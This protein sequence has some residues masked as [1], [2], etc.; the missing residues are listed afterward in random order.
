MSHEPTRPDPLQPL[1]RRYLLSGDEEAMDRLVDRT[2]P[3]L[4]AVARRIGAPQDAEDAV[5]GAYMALVRKRG[6]D[7]EAPVMP[8]L[9][10]T[11]IRLAYRRKAKH[12][13][14]RELASRLSR[15][16]DGEGPD[17]RA[18]DTERELLVRTAVAKLPATYRDAV[19]LRHLE[20]LSTRETAALLEVSE[21]AVRTRLHR[22]TRLLHGR[23]PAVL[24]ALLLFLPWG[25]ADLWRKLVPLTRPALGHPLALAG[26]G[27][28]LVIG[29]IALV[30]GFAGSPDAAA[31]IPPPPNEAAGVQPP[32]P[33]PTGQDEEPADDE[34]A[35]E[36]EDEPSPT[37]PKP[38]PR[39]VAPAPGRTDP[40]DGGRGAEPNPD[41]PLPEVPAPGGTLVDAGGAKP[42]PAP[43]GMVLLE[44]GHVP[45]GSTPQELG[46]LLDGRPAEIKSLFQFE[47]PL[48][49]AFLR[50]YYIARHEVTNAQYLRFLEDHRVAYK[51]GVRTEHSLESL[52]AQLVG[53]SR[54]EQRDPGQVVWLQ[55]YRANKGAI[56]RAFGERMESLFVWRPDRTVDEERT[57]RALRHER[58]PIGLTLGFYSRRPP[59]H[60]PAMKPPPGE[61]AHPVRFVDYND[62][63][64]FAEWAGLRLPTEAEWEW[65]ARGAKRRV[66]PWGDD[67]KKDA[68]RANWGGQV[69]DEAH[70]PTTLPVDALPAG[71]SWCELHH[72]CGNVAEWT[73][74][75]FV[76][77]PGAKAQHSY[78]GRWVKVIRGGGA[79]DGEML[80]LRSAC[81]NFVGAGPNAPPFPDNRFQWVGFRLA[82]WREPGRDHVPPIVRRATRPKKVKEGH[83]DPERFA[84]FVSRR[85]AKP[86]A[87][88]QDHVYVHGRARAVAFVPVASLLREEGLEAMRRAWKK[89]AD[90]RKTKGLLR[91][92]EDRP[93]TL[94]VLHVDL[95]LARMQVPVHEPAGA[96]KKRRRNTRGSARP[97]RTEPGVV[98]PGTYVLA[99]HWR[100][101]ALFTPSLEFRG[102]LPEPASDIP[103][104][105]VSPRSTKELG[106]PT[107]KPAL[108]RGEGDLDFAIPVGG[109]N[110]RRPY[111]LRVRVALPFETGALYAGGP[112]FTSR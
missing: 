39:P 26:I 79:G 89:P 50:P 85:W 17:R 99:V 25:A 62:A 78:M 98:S 7:L 43:P 55:L 102:F 33:E 105:E 46:R 87:S 34:P 76:P 106:P 58:L 1:V 24:L 2:R 93:W 45:I 16:S 59:A 100:R 74:S 38:E 18:L 110:G 82:S 109:K 73:S 37:E 14:Q 36:P 68:S 27:C 6:S 57:A 66:F 81:R 92:S 23:I 9:L 103:S 3:K 108:E 52:A 69:V 30:G 112:W 107:L 48:H 63:E 104:V 60:W 72:L 11:V 41:R 12:A 83:L 10:T 88:P 94:G 13:R 31:F 20:G 35:N 91:R 65:A 75:W 40:D 4:L 97:P 96:P 21:A 51:V 70:E 8:W 15:P 47:A 5:Q 61:S 71:R 67:W 19:V 84:A 44:G 90:F 95:P 29:A 56:W 53:Q 64:A 77:Y 42:A 86:N 101:L 80:V 22:A 32:Q 28:G 54:D 111:D 49:R